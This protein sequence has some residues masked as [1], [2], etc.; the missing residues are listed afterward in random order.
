MANK[1]HWQ[2]FD[3]LWISLQFAL[4]P[5]IF[6]DRQSQIPFELT[7]KVLAKLPSIFQEDFLNVKQCVLMSRWWLSCLIWLFQ[8]CIRS[9][10]APKFVCIRTQFVYLCDVCSRIWFSFSWLLEVNLC[11]L[12]MISGSSFWAYWVH[13]VSNSE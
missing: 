1:I 11:S 13:C 5:V 10:L 3:L 8:K 7:V 2:I 12:T 6:S 4:N 9:T